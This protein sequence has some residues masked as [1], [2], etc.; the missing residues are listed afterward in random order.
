MSRAEEKAAFWSRPEND[1]RKNAAPNAVDAARWRT[2]RTLS[3]HV[4]LEIIQSDWG[5]WERKLDKWV[6]LLRIGD[7][8]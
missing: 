8:R 5:E 2:L 4:V 6:K 1:R 3:H 7:G